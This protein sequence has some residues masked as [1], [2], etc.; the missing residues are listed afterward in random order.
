MILQALHEYYQ[1]KSADP[2]AGLAPPGFE[3]K[4]IPFIIVID[5]EGRLVQ[6]DDMRE[7][8]G[9]KRRAKIQLVP[10][11]VKRSVD[12]RAN[13]LCD[14]V[15]WVLGVSTRGKPERVRQQHEAF[16]DKLIEVFGS[17]PMDPGL[18]A[19]FAFLGRLG[20]HDFTASPAWNELRE[21][22]PF[23]TFRLAGD[24]HLVTQ[25][26][27]VRQQ[28]EGRGGPPAD[29]VCLVTG[30]DDVI[31][32]T[33]PSIK[34]V[35]DAQPFGANIVSF[36]LD[37][38]SSFG[39][40][41]GLNA[42]VG[43]KA[44]MAYTTALNHLLGR[45]SR[46]RMQVGDAT[47]VFW[48]EKS[49]GATVEQAFA[50]W[51][52]PRQDDPDANV[53]R[54]RALYEF[55]KGTPLTDDDDQRFY[56]LGLAPNK[57]RIVIRFWQV[58]TVREMG[59]RIFRHFS[60]LEIARSPFDPQYPSLYRLLLGLAPPTRDADKLKGL[61]P[62][63]PGD[64]MRA[65]LAGSPYPHGLLQAALRRCR[66]LR[67]VDYVR[68][69]LIKACLN[70]SSFRKEVKLAVSLDSDNT[71]TGYRLGRLFATFE[72]IQE[73]A[74]PGINATIRDRYFGAASS[75]PLV[76]FPLL[77]RLKNHHLAKIAN[78]GRVVNLERVIGAIMEGLDAARPFPPS[79]TLADQGRFA[80]GYYHQRQKFFEKIGGTQ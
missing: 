44:A 8:Q 39:K 28:I 80:V 11:S 75:N 77:N 49:S 69:A 48:A 40:E 9:K 72:K 73:E 34:G 14:T 4:E 68:A 3:L 70:R 63:L 27:H 60:D 32:V 62:R 54:I 76:V 52:D 41:Q 2:G 43:K 66:A 47:T 13:L 10:K 26:P 46:Q 12:V 56:V 30:L 23:V 16:R 36:N 58:A 74:N 18:K 67:D 33:H 17:A 79:L 57:A 7:G 55:K 35:R 37:A 42:P 21:M 45:D 31:E 24:S 51:F 15:E 59:E 78:P 65:I 1:R 19:V 53:E 25:R 50:A 6:I 20:E 61:Q 71:N 38:F 5:G 29:G 22:S 64:W